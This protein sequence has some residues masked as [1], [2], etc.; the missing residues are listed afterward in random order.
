MN[1][2]EAID[3]AEELQ[4]DAQETMQGLKDRVQE[5]QRIAKENTVKAAR[6][7]DTYVHDN[8]W[9]IIASVGIAAFAIGFLLGN[10]R[11]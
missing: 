8:P 10:R 5:W 9:T 4:S 6:A 11:D 2:N 1:A 3:K 7:T